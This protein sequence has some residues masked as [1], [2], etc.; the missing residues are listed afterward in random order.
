MSVRNLSL[1]LFLFK[2]TCIQVSNI[3]FAGSGD[4]AFPQGSI[5]Q[6]NPIGVIESGDV[7]SGWICGSTANTN[8][9]TWSLC[10][11]SGNRLNN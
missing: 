8:I 7:A 3:C 11:A 2:V 6:T 5:T 4:C 9:T 10:C 1:S